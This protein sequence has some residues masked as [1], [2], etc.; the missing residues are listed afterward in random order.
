MHTLSMRVA[1]GLQ[2]DSSRDA[3]HNNH[4]TPVIPGRWGESGEGNEGPEQLTDLPGVGERCIKHVAAPLPPE[5]TM[6]DPTIRQQP[7]YP[8]HVT[9]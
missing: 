6:T 9:S 5:H 8:E 3:A 7:P 4:L 1:K 2:R